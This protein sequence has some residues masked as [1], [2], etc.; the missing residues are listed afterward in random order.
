[1]DKINKS[2]FTQKNAEKEVIQSPEEIKLKKLEDIIQKLQQAVEKGN[3]LEQSHQEQSKRNTTNKSNFS[4]PTSTRMKEDRSDREFLSN[5]MN[6]DEKNVIPPKKM[7]LLTDNDTSQNI[8][9]R[10][11]FQNLSNLML[12]DKNIT[13]FNFIRNSED[14]VKLHLYSAFSKKSREIFMN[15]NHPKQSKNQILFHKINDIHIPKFRNVPEMNDN[16]DEIESNLEE[17]K[18]EDKIFIYENQENDN[19]NQNQNE[20]INENAEKIKEN[21]DKKFQDIYFRKENKGYFHIPS[22]IKISNKPNIKKDFRKLKTFIAQDK[23]FNTL[24]KEQK[25]KNDKSL[26]LEDIFWDPEIDSDTLSYINHNFICIEDIYNKQ[27]NEE[28]YDKNKPEKD[29]NEENEPNLTPIIAKELTSEIKTEMNNNYIDKDGKKDKKLTEENNKFIEFIA[30]NV[31]VTKQEYQV[32]PNFKAQEQFN[33][34]LKSDFNELFN[35][36]IEIDKSEFPK[37]EDLTPRR[38][39]RFMRFKFL[40]QVS[41]QIDFSLGGKSTEQSDKK[42][43]LSIE[44]ES[45][46]D[47]KN[48]DKNEEKNLIYL[49]NDSENEINLSINSKLEKDEKEEKEEKEE[50]K[51]K[52]EKEEKEEQEE[53][54]SDNQENSNYIY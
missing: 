25:K 40:G 41:K 27:N 29:I 14:R 7:H 21:E 46:K 3:N 12:D 54:E 15:E 42:M 13:E 11:K 24:K 45:K 49:D 38:I 32:M 31:G 20:N 51:E 30:I 28:K 47:K 9:S 5:F 2:H 50:K 43:D 1:M 37:G 34:Q 4:S 6:I 39:E 17:I 8:T 18:E 48:D 35:K 33:S 53:Q 19:N 26:D 52:E 22:L 23:M 10:E 36:Y 16:D 44:N